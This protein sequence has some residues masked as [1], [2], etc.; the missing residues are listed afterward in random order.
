MYVQLTNKV[1][2]ISCHI[3]YVYLP[4]DII[5]L[6]NEKK[7]KSMQLVFEE[8]KSFANDYGCFSSHTYYPTELPVK[9]SELDL[10]RPRY[11]GRMYSYSS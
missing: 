4:W 3:T 11:Q 9:S 2:Y 10:R 8:N 5:L 7:N 6:C 1:S